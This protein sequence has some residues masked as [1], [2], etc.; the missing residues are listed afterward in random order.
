MKTRRLFFAIW[1]TDQVRHSIVETFSQ[2]PQPVKGRIMQPHNLHVT[3]HFVGSVT[4]EMKDCMHTAAQT[5][6]SEPFEC[7]LDLFGSFR[8]AKILWMGCQ[9]VSVELTQLHQKLAVALESCGYQSE[10]RPF[11]PHLTLMRKYQGHLS[12]L[13]VDQIDFSIPWSVNEF[14]LVESHTDKQGVIYQV[15]EKYPLS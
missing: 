2:F 6:S 11:T 8:R 1:P 3:L 10:N 13:I 4:N 14:V 15:I 9:N 5:I 7:H 12:N